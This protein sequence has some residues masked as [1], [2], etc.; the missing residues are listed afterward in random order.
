MSYWYHPD[1]DKLIDTAWTTE[2]TDRTKAKQLYDQAQVMIH[3]QVP[4][5]YL[6]D[7]K[8]VFAVSTKLHDRP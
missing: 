3:D 8:A 6:W 2:A 7:L 1:Y 4:I 5:I